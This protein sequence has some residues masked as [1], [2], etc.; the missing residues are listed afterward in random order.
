VRNKKSSFRL[1]QPECPT[2][3]SEHVCVARS[4]KNYTKIVFD[5]ILGF[6]FGYPPFSYKLRCRQCG[7]EFQVDKINEK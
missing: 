2:C 6:F 1:I 7:H 3:K 5:I 4:F